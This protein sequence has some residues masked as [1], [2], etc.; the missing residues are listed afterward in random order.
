MSG[1]RLFGKDSKAAVF[2]SGKDKGILR[3][4][5]FLAQDI[6]N[7]TGCS[8]KHSRVVRTLDITNGTSQCTI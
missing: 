4:A 1:I 8:V 5:S 3:V 7:V 2:V 6:R